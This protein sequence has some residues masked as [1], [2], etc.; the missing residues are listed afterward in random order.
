MDTQVKQGRDV[1]IFLRLFL[2]LIISFVN[3]YVFND[4]AHPLNDE[5]FGFTE[6]IEKRQFPEHDDYC[7]LEMTPI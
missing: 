2:M 6:Y 4:E 7:P 3:Y 1:I 5:C